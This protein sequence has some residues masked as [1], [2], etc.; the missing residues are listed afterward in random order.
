M[1]GRGRQDDVMR[2]NVV[3]RITYCLA[4]ALLAGAALAGG[5]V[6]A[7]AVASDDAVKPSA[8]DGAALST[9]G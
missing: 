4:G 9:L 7:R 6:Q 8:T 3:P 1:A 2:R 5:S